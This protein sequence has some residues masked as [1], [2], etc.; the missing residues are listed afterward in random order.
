MSEP[1]TE[2]GRN[3]YRD[4]STIPA[5]TPYFDQIG[6]MILAIEAEAAPS[7]PAPREAP[8]DVGQ[9][10]ASLLREYT[11]LRERLARLADTEPPK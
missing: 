9:A 2:A 4:L 1:R 7:V 6:D 10:L 11:D 5:L 3:A 8:L